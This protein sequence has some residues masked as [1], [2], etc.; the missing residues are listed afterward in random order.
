M[1]RLFVVDLK[2]YDES[3]E[4]SK[5]T[6]VRA[7]IQCGDKLAMVHNKKYDYYEFSGGGVEEGEDF[8]HALIREIKEELG[9]TV[10]PE[11]IEDFGSVL[12][13]NSSQKYANT[14]YVQEIFYYTCKVEDVVGEQMLTSKEAEQGFSL[15]YVTPK[16]AIRKNMH[17]DHGEC[18]G[19]A[20]LE[21]EARIM[22]ML[23]GEKVDR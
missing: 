22:G 23:F 2:D 1:K 9:L 21:N 10:I 11:T 15:A 12:R 7:I 13:L 5:R 17:D 14:I 3:W 20:W 16:E 18:N 6:T 19:G 4:R 8:H